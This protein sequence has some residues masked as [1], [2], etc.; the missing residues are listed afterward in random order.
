MKTISA[1]RCFVNEPAVSSLKPNRFL[2]HYPLSTPSDLSRI[3]TE[4]LLPLQVAMLHGK[5]NA[6]AR[7]L[8]GQVT[9]LTLPEWR[10]MR[11]IGLD[12]GNSSATLR[13]A[14]LMDKGQ[15]SRTLTSLIERDLIVA[16]ASAQD[17]RQWHLELTAHGQRTYAELA[18]TFDARQAHLTAALTPQE[19]QTLIVAIDK[20][21]IAAQA[22]ITIETKEAV[23]SQT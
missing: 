16:Q 1:E 14:A 13:R 4:R 8:L 6:Q 23:S 19:L 10:V 9:D 21:G 3:Q 7:K 20:L 11:L 12:I 15:F 17:Q 22:D 2:R 18:P 5:L